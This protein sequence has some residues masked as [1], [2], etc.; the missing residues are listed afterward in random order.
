MEN[1]VVRGVMIQKVAIFW[2]FLSFSE[3]L[4]NQ[5]AHGTQFNDFLFLANQ[6]ARCQNHFFGF[7]VFPTDEPIRMLVPHQKQS[8]CSSTTGSVWNQIEFQKD[9]AQNIFKK[10]A[11]N[12][13]ERWTLPARSLYFK[14][15]LTYTRCKNSLSLSTI[16]TP[17]IIVFLIITSQMTN[18]KRKRSQLSKERDRLNS[19][20]RFRQHARALHQID[21][22]TAA[23]KIP[24]W[25]LI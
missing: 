4:A 11:R 14:I 24:K 20:R 5:N 6:N 21:L 15:T 17:F 12:S 13:N 3:L 19:L 7:W 9:W 8:D 1:I 18:Q 25:T 10:A 16:V 23:P 2:R 22:N